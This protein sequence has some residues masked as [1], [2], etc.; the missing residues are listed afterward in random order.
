MTY[1]LIQVDIMPTSL[2]IEEK[3][4]SNLLQ[5]QGEFSSDMKIMNELIQEKYE[6]AG[7]KNHNLAVSKKLTD[8]VSDNWMV[9]EIDEKGNQ[10]YVNNFLISDLKF[11]VSFQQDIDDTDNEYAQWMNNA[12]FDF[13]GAILTNIEDAPIE[14]AAVN[15][16][17]QS[18]PMSLATNIAKT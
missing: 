17:S 14:L 18:C 13:V 3:L 7:M 1:N 16:R 15:S 5:I 2:K 4:L 6:K 12:A 9:R 8:I 11:S 10:T